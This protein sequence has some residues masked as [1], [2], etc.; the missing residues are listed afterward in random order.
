[1][2]TWQMSRF[3]APVLRVPPLPSHCALQTLLPWQAVILPVSLP[4]GSLCPVG[5]LH[6]HFVR[7]TDP[8]HLSPPPVCNVTLIMIIIVSLIESCP[9]QHSY[10]CTLTLMLPSTT[11]C[12][13]AGTM[14]PLGDGGGTQHTKQSRKPASH[15]AGV[16]LQII[17]GRWRM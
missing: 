4:C 5:L 9:C 13:A 10:Q 2:I 8:S 7:R 11:Q 12:I 16:W 14:S 1:M 6:M 3:C 15:A 17:D